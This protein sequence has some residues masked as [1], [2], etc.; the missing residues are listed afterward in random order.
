MPKRCGC[1]HFSSVCAHRI[2]Y[3]FVITEAYQKELEAAE[4]AKR[5]TP[6]AGPVVISEPDQDMDD[7]PPADEIVERR[8]GDTVAPADAPDVPLRFSE[9]KRLDWEGK[10]CRLS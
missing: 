8:T 4:S 1:A 6:N 5:R 9:K 7:V 2:Q 10:T 3:T